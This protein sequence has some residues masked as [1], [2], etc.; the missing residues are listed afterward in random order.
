M[1]LKPSLQIQHKT[2]INNNNNKSLHFLTPKPEN[3]KENLLRSKK[4][5]FPPK[6][7]AHTLPKSACFKILM[8]NHSCNCLIRW[9]DS[10]YQA[11]INNQPTPN[12]DFNW[13]IKSYRSQ[14]KN[15]SKMP[16]LLS[17]HC[18]LDTWLSTLYVCF[19]STLINK[20]KLRA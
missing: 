5:N 8:E 11:I 16:Y 13:L 1:T 2:K 7:V 15:S 12:E 14:I 3:N 6:V 20:R 4:K 17:V 9:R 19:Y 18:V 10:C